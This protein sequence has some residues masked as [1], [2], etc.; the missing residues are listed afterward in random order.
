MTHDEVVRAIYIFS[1]IFTVLGVCIYLIN[2]EENTIMIRK[3]LAAPFLLMAM[4]MFVTAEAFSFCYK[5]I[6]GNS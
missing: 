3:I 6:A 1:S 2:L 4:L 5:K